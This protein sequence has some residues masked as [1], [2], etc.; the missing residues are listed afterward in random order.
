M[1]D[2]GVIFPESDITGVVQR[3]LDV[4]MAAD[5]VASL[6]RGCSGIG[7]IIGN[8]RGSAPHAGLGAAMQHVA[9]NTNELLDQ[10][11]PLGLSHGTG[12]PEYV[13]RAGFLPIA[14]LG[15]RS[16]AAFGV[17][18]GTECFGLLQQGPLIVFQLD[19]DV[20]LRRCGGL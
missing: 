16:I 2:A 14:A 5:S 15:D 11:A 19:D 8:L 1:P 13:S 6:T 7:N 18:G 4:P 3:V 12:G 17:A 9:G 20:R 10:R